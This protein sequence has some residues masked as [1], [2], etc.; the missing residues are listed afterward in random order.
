MEDTVN[1]VDDNTLEFVTSKNKT[2]VELQKD[3]E[4]LENKL[5]TYQDH[6]KGIENEIDVV[7]DFLKLLPN[8]S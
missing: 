3:L 1:V 4:Q 6:I 5:V 7:K 8:E 2:R